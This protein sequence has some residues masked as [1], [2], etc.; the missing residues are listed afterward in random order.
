MKI[1]TIMHYE[2]VSAMSATAALAEAMTIVSSAIPY[3]ASH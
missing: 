1:K 2:P 3:T